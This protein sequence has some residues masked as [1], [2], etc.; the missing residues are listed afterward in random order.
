MSP[1]SVQNRNL[2][3]TD[4]SPA[5]SVRGPNDAH[6]GRSQSITSGGVTGTMKI[7]Q[8][9]AVAA[10]AAMLLAACGSDD[11]EQDAADDGPDTA[12]TDEADDADDADDADGTDDWPD[13]IILGLVP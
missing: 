10:A 6:R 9:A 8:W 11:P 13:E 12:E 7:R 5:G 1:I 4:R 2:V 3:F